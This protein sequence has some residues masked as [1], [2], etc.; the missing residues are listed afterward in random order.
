MCCITYH[1]T[2]FSDFIAQFAALT[3]KKK[4]IFGLLFLN[5]KL[6]F[7]DLLFWVNNKRLFNR[8]LRKITQSYTI[9]DND[10]YHSYQ[11]IFCEVQ[12]GFGTKVR[13][14]TPL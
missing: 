11:V 6:V 13:I 14:Q 2:R 4:F 8:A 7:P 12:N 5:L 9:F 3:Y 10:S 1:R